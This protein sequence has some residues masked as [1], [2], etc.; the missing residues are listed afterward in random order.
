MALLLAILFQDKDVALCP[1]A[2]RIIS[3][4]A[5]LLKSD[6]VFNRYFAAQAMGS[7]VCAGDRGVHLAAANSG[8][9]GSLISLMG[10]IEMESP[11]LLALS[12]EFSLLQHPD[13]VVMKK[14]F[15]IDDIRGGST[16]RKS[17]PL[18]VDLL[19]P[20]PDRPGAPPIAVQLLTQLADGNEANKLAMADAG[21]LEALTKYLSLSP[22]DYTEAAVTE[23][24]R[25]L[26]THP[27]LLRHEASASSVSQLVAVLR[28]GSRNARFGAAKAL[29]ALFDSEIVRD[30]EAARQALQPL[31]DMLNGGTEKEQE[32]SL[33]ALIKLTSGNF[34]KSYVL[35]DSDG[36]PMN[37]LLTI[38]VSSS[39][40]PE[41][42][43]KVADFC[44]V[45]FGYPCFLSKP[46]ASEFVQPLITLVAAAAAKQDN[47]ALDSA[48]RTLDQLLSVDRHAEMA[49]R[50][51]VI[52]L[53]VGLLSPSNC[54]LSE[55]CAGALMKLG[56]DRPDCKLAMVNCRVIDR[57]LELLAHASASLCSQTVE[58]LLILT[59][60]SSIARSS[61]AA[62]M[63]EP[64][65]LVLR[66]ADMSLMGHQSALQTLVNILEKPQSL[67]AL[68]LTPSQVIE[69]LLSFLESPS[70]A[71]QQLGTELLSHLLAQEHFQQ[72]IT[73]KNAVVPLV[74]LAGIGILSLQQTA[75]KALESISSTWP[76]AV[77]D[78]GGLSEI[79]KVIVQS[80]PEPS[81]SL[82][83]SAAVVLCNVLRR[84]P[85]QH[86]KLQLPVLVRLLHSTSESTAAAALSA[87]ITQERGDAAAALIM[88][89]HGALAPLLE[90]LR[91]HLCEE[92]AATLLETLLNNVRVRE[93]K[94]AKYAIAPLAQ[95]LLDPQTRSAPARLLAAL[96]LGDLFQNESL[97][98][99]GD[100][101]SACRALVSL[102][103]DQPTEDMKMVAVCALQNLVA[104]SRTNRRAVAEAGGI[105]V[106]Q[107]LL[108]SPNSDVAAQAA[109]LIKFLFSNHTLQEYVSNELIRSLTGQSLCLCV[110]VWLSLSLSLSLAHSRGR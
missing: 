91:S 99:T 65:F 34:S 90:L 42:K 8:G 48:V 28:L 12:M 13:Q 108:L 78:A 39:S 40:S 33:S 106:I 56:K 5:L 57:T 83:E 11:D 60:N 17:I 105:L 92:A 67:A 25:I 23:L 24:L 80:D 103:E 37:T 94:S 16:A 82:W 50:P 87:L 84:N 109:L 44:F 59:N 58:L 35:T 7:L 21:A 69:P 36:D 45:L 75:V 73:T 102:L 96:A 98:R 15:Q 14:L 20:M 81:L 30:S 27:D 68:R 1:A 31:I 101:V 72:D 53:L 63:V 77:A 49:A 104:R 54:A 79:S 43:K 110:S 89:E 2:M 22:Q 76:T 88:A 86:W 85:E 6:R 32:A 62:Q 61:A 4:L 95:Y 93:T 41:L 19:R 100:A 52:S 46:S 29:Q 51:T 97:A 66:R 10:H 55:A 18:L 74:Q 38:L 107:E 3:P 47:P 64:L 70:Q 71:I 9:V 26:F